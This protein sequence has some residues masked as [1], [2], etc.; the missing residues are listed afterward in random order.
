MA[1]R[2]FSD[3][4]YPTFGCP[5]CKKGQLV[6]DANSFEK[7]EPKHSSAAHGHEAWDPDWIEYRFKIRY[8]CNVS[9][10]GE[11]SHAIGVG[12]VDQR[13]D[14]D[15][16]TEWYEFFHV[17]AFIPAPYLVALPDSAPKGVIKHVERSFALFWLDVA[18][19]TNSLRASIEFLLDELKVPRHQIDKNGNTKVISLHSRIELFEKQQP[20]YSELLIALK[21]VGN[22]GSHGGDI[23][24]NDFLDSLKIY[25]HVLFEL[26]ENNAEEMKKLA[27]KL[28]EKVK[29]AAM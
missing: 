8:A 15:G 9:S 23:Q 29:T 17:K 28:R 24:D 18:S 25:S 4:H 7:I 5:A 16:S 6:A 12:S 21:E 13:Y 10:C 20:N 3:E 11:I 27:K 2:F 22:L 1:S 19:A 26:F 14:Y